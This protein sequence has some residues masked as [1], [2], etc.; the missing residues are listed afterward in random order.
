MVLLKPFI[1]KTWY[2]S[3]LVNTLPGRSCEQQNF[4]CIKWFPLHQESNVR[5]VLVVEEVWV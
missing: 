3:K 2:L 5:H 1:K 4:V